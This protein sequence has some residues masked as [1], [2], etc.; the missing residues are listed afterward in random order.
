[1]ALPIIAKYEPG[2]CA[3]LG[4]DSAEGGHGC[5]PTLTRERSNVALA[6]FRTA[7][8]STEH[9][10][11]VPVHEI[12]SGDPLD[13]SKSF[14]RCS[15][16]PAWHQAMLVQA[17]KAGI[18]RARHP[19]G[20]DGSVCAGAA[21][22]ACGRSGDQHKGRSPRDPRRQRHVTLTQRRARLRQQ[23]QLAAI[24]Q[25]LGVLQRMPASE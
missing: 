19:P 11:Q 15:A 23:R 25:G 8:S 13:D 6:S 2:R 22:S 1:M 17:D 24:R 5:W 4:D 14:L 10:N 18:G 3:W 16:Q 20:W 9:Q 21:Q 7:N 12:V